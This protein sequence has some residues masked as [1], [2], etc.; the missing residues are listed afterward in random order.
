[1][2][3]SCRDTLLATLG[4]LGASLACGQS[5]DAPNVVPITAG[6][7]TSGQPSAQALATLGRL[8][9]QAVIYL[10]PETV[11]DAVKEEPELLAA[12]GIEFV[13]VPIP[14]AAPNE[15]HFLAVAAALERLHGRKV[16]VH[17][18]VNM[19]ASSMVFLYRVLRRKEDP[20]LA[21]EA[22]AGVWSPGGP[23][24][25]L[26]VDQLRKHQVDFDLY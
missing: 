24:R 5:I 1:M 26:L 25:K 21:Y 15:Q 18:Q 3:N 11:A 13:H 16:L 20:A 14:F 17:C 10:A 4:A 6:L 2:A 19:R 9:F 7:V 23:W 12:Q 22:V 8:G